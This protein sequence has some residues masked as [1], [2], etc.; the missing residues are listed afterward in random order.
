MTFYKFFRETFGDLINR[1]DQQNCVTECPGQRVLS[2]N[3]GTHTFLLIFCRSGR[4]ISTSVCITDLRVSHI[5]LEQKSCCNSGTKV[6][7]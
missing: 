6:I 5:E 3:R 7:S 1:T 2:N 4:K